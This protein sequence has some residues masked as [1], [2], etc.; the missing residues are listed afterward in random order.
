MRYFRG[1]PD[2]TP[3]AAPAEELQRDD[4]AEDAASDELEE[5]ASEEDAARRRPR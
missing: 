3:T 2:P 1:E 4:V 5:I